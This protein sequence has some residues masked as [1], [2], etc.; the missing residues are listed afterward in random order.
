MSTSIN[1]NIP[2]TIQVS[3]SFNISEYVFKNQTAE[4]IYNIIKNEIIKNYQKDGEDILIN[5]T[6]NF[7]MQIT[8]IKNE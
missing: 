2:S 3:N 4:Q 6:N 7:V 5:T 1:N 8:L